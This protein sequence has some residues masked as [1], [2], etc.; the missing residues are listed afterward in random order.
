M[1]AEHRPDVVGQQAMETDMTE[2]QLGV[3]LP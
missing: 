2:S 3:G 1:L